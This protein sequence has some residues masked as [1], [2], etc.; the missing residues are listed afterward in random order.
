MAAAETATPNLSAQL[1]STPNMPDFWAALILRVLLLAT[2]LWG[3]IVMTSQ[4][5]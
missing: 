5:N 4:S 2:S 1:L 3:V